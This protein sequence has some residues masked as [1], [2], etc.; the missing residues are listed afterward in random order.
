MAGSHGYID[1]SRRSENHNRTDYAAAE[2]NCL[3]SHRGQSRKLAARASA[4]DNGCTGY[5][6]CNENHGCIDGVA[7]GTGCKGLHPGNIEVN[8]H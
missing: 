6:R 4:G 3:Q 7:A 8:H 5:D 2:T 1:C